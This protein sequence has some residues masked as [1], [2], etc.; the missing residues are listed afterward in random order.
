MGRSP[1]LLLGLY[2]DDG[3]LRLRGL[4]GRP[5]KNEAEIHARIGRC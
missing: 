3:E 1:T 5:A 4:G 2:E